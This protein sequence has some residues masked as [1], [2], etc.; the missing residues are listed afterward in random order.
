LVVVRVLCGL[1]GVGG[2]GLVGVGV[3]FLATTTEGREV[4]KKKKKRNLIRAGK[5]QGLEKGRK[6]PLYDSP[7]VERKYKQKRIGK[8]TGLNG[9]VDEG[10][11]SFRRVC[12][13]SKKKTELRGKGYT[14][15]NGLNKGS[16]KP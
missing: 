12:I 13:P 4:A 2:C 7:V 3:F 8:K 6:K 16:S 11:I 15:D 9:Q 1:E 10:L 5:G 14:F